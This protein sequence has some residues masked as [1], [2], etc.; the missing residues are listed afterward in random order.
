[1][2]RYTPALLHRNS[3]RPSL[4]K[5]NLAPDVRRSGLELLEERALL[6]ATPMGSLLAQ[7]SA[8]EASSCAALVSS[9]SSLD[10]TPTV[11]LSAALD[12]SA[13][14]LSGASIRFTMQSLSSGPG[15]SYD[16]ALKTQRT[17]LDE[18]SNFY[19]DLWAYGNGA[20]V[21]SV[22]A[23]FT[24]GADCFKLVDVEAAEGYSI[25]YST[26]AGTTS[27]VATGIGSIDPFEETL[28]ARMKYA[29]VADA[30]IPTAEDGFFAPVDAGFV[31]DPASQKINGAVV[32][33]V[34]TPNPILYPFLFDVDENG[35][36]NAND[37]GYFLSYVGQD[38]DEIA[39]PKY[40]V[41]DYDHNG[42]IN[43]NDLA[44]FLLYL[45]VSAGDGLE[46]A[47]RA[48]PFVGDPTVLDAPSGVSMSVGGDYITVAWNEVPNA[49]QYSVAYKLASDA[50]WTTCDAVAALR[51]AIT[52][53][54]ADSEYSVRVVARGNG[55]RYVDSD[56]SDSFL[57][58]TMDASFFSSTEYDALRQRYDDLSLPE[59]F[60]DVN[61]VVPTD[62]TAQALVDAIEVAR[63][64]SCDDVILLDPEKYSNASL[65]LS[66]DV[67]TLDVD[68]ESSGAISIV[69]RGTDRAQIVAN[70]YDVTFDAT[71]GLT[72][73]GG[74]DFVEVNPYVPTCQA[75][76][77]SAIGI[78]PTAIETQNVGAYTWT[79]VSVADAAQNFALAAKPTVSATPHSNDYALLFVGG[80]GAKSNYE[81][82]Y[83]TLRDYYYELVEDFHLDPTK[84]Y[85]L[86]ADGDVTGTSKNM[87][88]G[89][90]KE[91]NLTTSNMTFA[92][93]VGT[94][95]RAA[96]GANLT[97]TLGKI[98][99][100]MTVDSHLL[101][102]TYD[103]GSGEGAFDNK[104]N[105]VNTNV[106][107]D[108][109]DYLCGWTY[110]ITGETVRDALFQIK[111]GYVTCVFTQCYSGG[112]LDDI[113][114]PATGRLSSL[115]TGSALFAAGA[116]TNHF[117]VNISGKQ[118]KGG[119]FVGYIGYA[120]TF[121]EAMRKCQDST[122]ED[123]FIY[124]EQNSPYSVL[125]KENN[126]NETYS[127]NKGAFVYQ[128][129]HPWHVGEPFSIFSTPYEQ[130]APTI[131]SHSG[132]PF[133][134]SLTWTA[135]KGAT[136]YTLEYAVGGSEDVKTVRNISANSY[137]VK[138]LNPETNYVFK[139]RANNSP[140]S[141]PATVWTYPDI[142]ETPSTV[143][144]TP[145]DVV[146]PYDGKIS[147][148]EALDYAESG[149][150]ITFANSLKGK[151]I[152]LDQKLGQLTT[153]KTLAIDASNLWDATTSAPGITI[154]GQGET[155]ILYLEEGADVEINRITFRNGRAKGDIDLPYCGGAICNNGATLSLDSCVI[156][157][158]QAVH[159]GG[160]VYSIGGITTF[161]NCAVTNNTS[162]IYG[163]GGIYNKEGTLSLVNCEIRY[164]ESDCGGGVYSNGS[165][166]LTNCVVAN[167]T[168]T[169]KS[170]LEGG[171]G[172][173]LCGSATLYSCTI[174]GNTTSFRGGGIFLSGKSTVFNA[175]N[176]IIAG[177][178]ATTSAD[179]YV[180]RNIGS[181]CASNT[182]S[183]YS[184][185]MIGENN[186]TYDASQPLF[187]KSYRLAKNSQAINQGD[188]RYVKTS[189]DFTGNLR[190]VGGAVDLGAY[191]YQFGTE[192]EPQLIV[193]TSIADIVN[194]N[195]EI[196]TL[197]E[198]LE[199]AEPGATITFAN[200]L[201]GKTIAVDQ[202]QFR[203]NKTLMIDASNLYDAT[204]QTP[205]IT[206]SGQGNHR[207]LLVDR[208]ADVEI[209][210]I[211]FTNSAGSTIYSNYARLSLSNCVISDNHTQ[212][213]DGGGIYSQ[214]STTTLSN[215]IVA[216]NTAESGSGGGIYQTYGTL[217]L[218]NCVISN[219]K[220]KNDG[221]GV[222]FNGGAMTLANCVLTNNYSSSSL[223][224]AINYNKYS[225]AGSGLVATNCLVAGNTTGGDYGGGLVL[226]GGK[227]TIYNCTI[228]GN[229]SRN[230]G[231]G[232]FAQGVGSDSEPYVYAM[233]NTIVACNSASSDGA[234]V[235]K[236]ENAVVN[237][238][239]TL[240]SNTNWTSGANNLTYNAS[241]PLFTNAA[242][243]D[244]TLAKNSQAIDKGNN[245]YVTESVDLAGKLR[246]S[247]GTVDLGAY[248]YK[249]AEAPSTVVTTAEDVVDEFDEEISLR[250]ALGYANPGDTITFVNSLKGK[251]I[252]LDP[253]LGQLTANKSVTI[254]ASSL[255]N[256]STSAPGLTISGQGTTRI[257]WIEKNDDAEDVDVGING[258]TLT[259]GY[260]DENGGAVY[261]Y[262]ATLSLDNCVISGN[263]AYNWGGG[264]YSEH[265][266][267]T[268]TNCIVTNNAAEVCGGGVF[269]SYGQ[270]TLVNCALSNNTTSQNG[271][272][273]IYND[274]GMLSLNNCKIC[275]NESFYAG[276]GVFSSDGETTLVN[277]T[278]ANNTALEGGG[279]GIESVD[280]VTTLVN[281]AVTNNTASADNGG[282][283]A[284]FFGET[285]LVNC[286]ITNNTAS[287]DEEGYDGCG[288]GVYL[289]KTD[290]FVVYNTII[291]SNSATSSGADV[292]LSSSDVV[293]KAY[294]TLSS[295]SNWTSGA[296]NLTY[297][298]SKPLFT[299]ATSGDYTLAENS[300]AID[301][302]NNKHVTTNVDLAGNARVFGGTVDVGAY[303][304]RFEPL[305]MVVTTTLDTVDES[306]G[307]ISLREALGAVDPSGT[308]TFANSLKGETIYLEGGLT[309][310]KST[311]IDA[312]NLCDAATQTPGLTISGSGDFRILWLNQGVDVKIIGIT[313]SDG[314]AHTP[315][316][317]DWDGCGGAIFND[318][319]TLSLDNC[320][321]SNNQAETLSDDGWSGCGGAI[322]NNDGKLSFNKCV[323]SD[324]SACYGGGVYSNDGETT[325]ANC[326]VTN[327]IGEDG[328][329]G[330]Y[331]G[332][333]TTLTNCVLT[334][335]TAVAGPNGDGGAIFGYGEVGAKLSLD[336]CLISGNE[337]INGGG[338]F[339]LGEMTASFTNCTI[340]NNA[341]SE[342]GGVYITNDEA[343]L[344]NCLIAGNIADSGGGLELYFGNATLYN[345]TI[346][347]N[348]ASNDL[349]EGDYFGGGVY[350]FATSVLNAYNTII[351][352]N[353][354]AGSGVDVYIDPEPY[355]NPVANA[356]NT[357]SSYADWTSGAKNLSYNSSKP[358]FTNAAS[359]DYTL[360][361]NSQA[362]SKGNNQYVTE[363]V[364]L[365]GK[366]RIVG[367]TVDLGAYEYQS[368]SSALFDE[369][370]EIFDEME[371]SLD[372]IAASLL[373][374]R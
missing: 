323:I 351:A 60:A 161:A 123:A 300:Q 86:Y 312:S 322:F 118:S 148:R 109:Y 181:T 251:T 195:D 137:T 282:G 263:E 120:Q 307:L 71:A 373:E 82:Y 333:E 368:A 90:S 237:A 360:A 204:T 240:S 364:D 374:K 139:V 79:G 187:T 342:G 115:Y 308:I 278:V 239:N 363:S 170:E 348:T 162:S 199:Y 10:Q 38:V 84:I 210:G 159:Y 203:T 75:T 212:Y 305:S 144:T 257:L 339:S 157:D 174:A 262:G 37:L 337:A 44:Y 23:S 277:C 105:L 188:N 261:N 78:F 179:V 367:G 19:V 168:A 283:V 143:V 92:T 119:R 140:Y 297:D 229:T 324:N 230:Y 101:F 206:I 281:C 169:S 346:V 24:C 147:L 183:S 54:Q 5:E 284:V 329:G 332:G 124:T 91:P 4:S 88:T 190:I 310:S 72:Q 42:T 270:A 359:G 104:G 197:R 48:E 45:G 46:S 70:Y 40:R 208:G 267:T 26:S 319:A 238:Y 328:G 352:N 244:Y 108:Y 231:G 160:G 85:I 355:Y 286:T 276:G 301:K 361:K 107:N 196:V 225:Y 358:L 269:S 127:R 366:A 285:T 56:W 185:W 178:S 318:G 14:T 216:N 302:G 228:I 260:S 6:S 113:F 110:A 194:D 327:N 172:L 279:G 74:F 171:G 13:A 126:I 49:S 356:Y 39:Y 125:N 372:L 167:N 306:D 182:L 1:M 320:V 163:G 218:N 304:S 52:G 106:K 354:T 293:T 330:I 16:A 345:C 268:L 29:P 149:A 233:Y 226:R 62:W 299:N 220:A 94:T 252:A 335:N 133:S 15:D 291:A 41:L 35:V 153:N 292:S 141:A 272:G 309:A 214:Y 158:N 264:V 130:G 55:G 81:R 76:S 325:L 313:L 250:E 253:E 142:L 2:T 191:E 135:V 340:T 311:T 53:L 47:Y 341:A 349:Y 290:S 63:S 22:E 232:V 31:A 18:W 370:A 288:G 80:A 175:Y 235:Y 36:V 166:T 334:N 11:D 100:L 202:G 362:I 155:R 32:E 99:N 34:E 184:S 219:N 173:T 326:T 303:E 97:S 102:W 273:A 152:A 215:C 146:N 25:E 192:P 17:W 266:E 67:V 151:T 246:I 7:Y 275:D 317:G 95:V 314:Y 371:D 255:W 3:R 200:S 165:A 131:A 134:I 111:Q 30:G 209:N 193:V 116:S 241:K 265:G 287:E 156:S 112:I 150:A 64:T 316:G 136:S 164:N 186:L 68:Y 344:V 9:A 295:Y 331:S 243:G 369:D 247:G 145:L 121:A 245:Q 315:G 259:N 96:N 129:Q 338:V 298:A 249:S 28:V 12:A 336:N 65:D 224:G 242:T 223:G 248:E 271:G 132:T 357:L 69:S 61:I 43:T 365:A 57:V 8:T 205:G 198:A 213:Y 27:V 234:D 21:E 256:A 254:D 296:N 89:S 280:C 289:Y 128:M 350:V 274:S 87:N 236:G 258:I 221:G 77:T 343:A 51:Y 73:L 114:D 207:I 20:I 353:S 294:N 66:N 98:A 189:A 83:H 154:S 321:I 50:S 33:S 176:T 58:K 201:K 211:T 59:S 138:G 347:D 217:S 117:E 180:N 227:S 122:G 103:H 93:S 177:N 222:Y